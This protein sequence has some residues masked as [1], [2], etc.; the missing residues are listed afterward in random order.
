MDVEKSMGSIDSDDLEN[1]PTLLEKA[2]RKLIGAPRD[3]N[4]P[5]IF[6]KLSLIPVLAW[7]GLGPMVYLR[8]LMVQKRLIRLLILILIYLSFWV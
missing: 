8:L 1:Q 3:V 4:E 5:S 6:H 7:I 2:R